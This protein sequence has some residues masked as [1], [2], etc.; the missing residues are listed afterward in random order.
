MLG[1][2]L[3]GN[4][5]GMIPGMQMIELVTKGIELMKGLFDKGDL[6][7]TQKLLD[8]LNEVVNKEGKGG[9]QQQ[10]APAEQ[11]PYNSPRAW[12]ENPGSVTI[13]LEYG[14]KNAQPV[15]HDKLPL[16]D[17]S[18]QGDQKLSQAARPFVDGSEAA[19]NRALTPGSNEWLTVMWA[20]QQNPNVRYDADSQRFTM[21]MSDGTS[22]DLGS[23]QEAQE[24]IGPQ[25]MNRGT[26]EGFNK[27]GD[28][29]NEKVNQAKASP[30]TAEITITVSQAANSANK[31]AA[32]DGKEHSPEDVKKQMDTL[33]NKLK[34][35]EDAIRLLEQS[36]R[37]NQPGSLDVN[38]NV[39]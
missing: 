31:A 19:K 7:G 4:P 32:A 14:N 10:P 17:G 29:L 12:D 37:M 5:L 20:M 9:P 18:P 2:I 11:Q 36:Q 39:A 35:F 3:G 13:K 26:N 30:A 16:V 33:R 15:A 34:E 1:G 23:L 21:K 25:G 28:F 8:F 6:Q 24:R 38:I 22:R 27:M